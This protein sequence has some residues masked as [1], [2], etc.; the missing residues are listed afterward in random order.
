MAKVIAR[1]RRGNS[2]W[3]EEALRSE[4]QAS[5]WIRSTSIPDQYRTHELVQNRVFFT[6]PQGL[7]THLAAELGDDAFDPEVQVLE[8]ALSQICG[9]HTQHVGFWRNAPVVYPFLRRRPLTDTRLGEATLRELGWDMT[10][11]QA[12]S[13]LKLAESRTLKYFQV[14]QGY[15]GWLM[16]NST[17][18]EEHDNLLRAFPE[19]VHDFG[20][21]GLARLVADGVSKQLKLQALS[22]A[23]QYYER[24][25]AFCMRWRLSGLAAPNLPMPLQPQTPV[26]VPLMALGP[27]KNVGALFYLP[28]T[29]PV[30]GRDELRNMM[31]DALRGAESPEHLAGWTKLVRSKNPAKNQ[32]VRFGRIFELQHYCRILQERYPDAIRRQKGDLEHALATFMNVSADTTHQDLLLVRRRLGRDWM[33]RGNNFASV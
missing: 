19:E 22:A 26:P 16:T 3:S 31:E 6:L 8:F 14:A 32:I 18:I 5:P 25:E 1:A 24:F 11:A 20:L 27:M 2:V 23:S 30:P 10:V 28:D 13:S 17:F 12:N 33:L 21:P 15:A 4:L 9:D 29:Y 7:L